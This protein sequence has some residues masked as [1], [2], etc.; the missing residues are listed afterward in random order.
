MTLYS[1]CL[2]HLKYVMYPLS[3]TLDTVG[4]KTG[5]KNSSD[6]YWSN[7]FWISSLHCSLFFWRITILVPW[8]LNWRTRRPQ[9]WSVCLHCWI[10]T[11]LNVAVCNQNYKLIT[12]NFCVKVLSLMDCCLGSI[13]LVWR[14]V[15]DRY[16]QVSC[17]GLIQVKSGSRLKMKRITWI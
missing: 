6:W 7:T 12:L 2:S 1:G 16:L 17:P 13:V 10:F 8:I 4:V 9:I 5:S 11:Q 3:Q 15:L 14:S